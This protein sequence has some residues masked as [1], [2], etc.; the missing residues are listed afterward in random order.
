MSHFKRFTQ[1]VLLT[2]LSCSGLL[3]QCQSAGL[4]SNFAEFVRGTAQCQYTTP[5]KLGWTILNGADSST[6]KYVSAGS[7]GRVLLWETQRITVYA[8]GRAYF[9][10]PKSQRWTLEQ[11]GPDADNKYRIR[12][13]GNG[14]YITMAWNGWYWAGEGKP[15]VFK[16]VPG[17]KGSDRHYILEDTKSEYFSVGSDGGLVRWSLTGGS[18]QLFAIHGAKLVD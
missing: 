11:V 2:A 14:Q 3:A 10:P 16:F 8:D 7:N 12:N 18:T 6:G 4:F 17:P 15:T 9:P 1:A 13:M 5:D